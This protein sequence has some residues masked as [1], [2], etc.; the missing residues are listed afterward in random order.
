MKDIDVETIAPFPM[1]HD[2]PREGVP[3]S[4]LDEFVIGAHTYAL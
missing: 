1:F 2:A 3:L 4:E